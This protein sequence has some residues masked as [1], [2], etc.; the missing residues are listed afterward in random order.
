MGDLFIKMDPSDTGSRA[1]GFGCALYPSWVSPSLWVD[2]PATATS[3][4]FGSGST[5]VGVQVSNITQVWPGDRIWVQAWVVDPTT[6]ASASGLHQSTQF[7]SENPANK[8]QTLTTQPANAGEDWVKAEFNWHPSAADIATGHLCIM[9]NV[10]SETPEGVALLKPDA[11]NPCADQHHAQANVNV[12]PVGMMKRQPFPGRFN[13]FVPGPD[14]RVTTE[15]TLVRAVPV[16]EE[17]RMSPVIQEHLL[18]NAFVDLVGGEEMAGG[19]DPDC[20]LTEPLERIRLRGGGR[21]V[22]AH[23]DGRAE[24]HPAREPFEELRIVGEEEVF[25]DGRLILRPDASI[26]LRLEGQIPEEGPGAVHE[27]DVVE[28]L[29]DGTVV[30][31]IRVVFLVGFDWWDACG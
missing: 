24:L 18:R 15:E 20:C 8:R 2:A 12:I 30:G 14:A 3:H 27:V 5:K 13:F 22:L 4:N 16:P 10:W 21:L 1:A 11:V 19:V 17:L 25:D 28:T 7:N 26:P 6:R 31:G 23:S 29:P 9:A